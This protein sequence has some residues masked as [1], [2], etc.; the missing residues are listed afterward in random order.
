VDANLGG[1]AIREVGRNTR[2]ARTCERAEDPS[3]DVALFARDGL[4]RKERRG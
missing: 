4:C 1:S 2:E 3:H